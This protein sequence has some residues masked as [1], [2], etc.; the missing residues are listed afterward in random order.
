[1][2]IGREIVYLLATRE[3]PTI[4]G[5][6]WERIFAGSIGAEWKPSNVGLDD[7]VLGVFAWGAKTVK[8]PKPYT[9]NTV[10]LISGRNSLKYSFGE[11]KLDADPQVL[12]R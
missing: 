12:G 4:E 7:I 6:D 5:E 2:K 11:N 10:R 8:N 3:K 1:M 9:A